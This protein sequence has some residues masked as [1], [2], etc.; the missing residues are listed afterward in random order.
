MIPLACDTRVKKPLNTYIRRISYEG[1]CVVAAHQYLRAK[2]LPGFINEQGM[3]DT[4]RKSELIK[5]GSAVIHYTNVNHK[6]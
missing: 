2:G 4:K 1:A 5:L 3:P 6:A